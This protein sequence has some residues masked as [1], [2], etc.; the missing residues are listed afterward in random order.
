MA[1]SYFM[2]GMGEDD[3]RP[4]KGWSQPQPEKTGPAITPDSPVTKKDLEGLQ[5]HN[6]MAGIAGAIFGTFLLAGLKKAFSR[7]RK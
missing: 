4:A 7:K 2:S 1:R 6:I 3:S 5:R